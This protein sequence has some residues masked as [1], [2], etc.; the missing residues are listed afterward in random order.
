[1]FTQSW[2]P[3][4]P[5]AGRGAGG[6]RVW[7]EEHRG[8]RI[9]QTRVE[10]AMEKSPDTIAVGCPFCH[11]MLK[12]GVNEKQVEGVQTKDIAELVSESL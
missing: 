4:R 11:M 6:A 12:D 8:A 2:V 3:G 9:N 10:Q 7:M 5:V 1:M